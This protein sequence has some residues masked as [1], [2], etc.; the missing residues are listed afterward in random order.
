[1][2][3]TTASQNVFCTI[4]TTSQYKF[5]NSVSTRSSPD[6][7]KIRPNAREFLPA[8]ENISSIDSFISDL[9]AEDP[10]LHAEMQEA[11]SWVGEQYFGDKQ[12]LK[13]LRLKAGLSQIELAKKLETSQPQVAKL[14]KGEVDPRLST[15]QRLSAVLGV[16]IGEVAAA[17]DGSK[18]G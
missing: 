14:E 9:L 7:E 10:S 1:M 3:Q 12:S 15:V 17:M 13:A 4:I 2:S 18:N 8:R 6:S 5:D 11:R 16:S